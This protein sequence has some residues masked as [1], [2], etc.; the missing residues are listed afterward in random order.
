MA[1]VNSSFDPILVMEILKIT[2]LLEDQANC[3]IWDLQKRS[4]FIIKSA[5]KMIKTDLENH[6]GESSNEKPMYYIMENYLKN[7]SSKKGSSYGVVG[8]Q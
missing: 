1:K 2:L 6:G 8:M 4:T 5:H 3:L 7:A